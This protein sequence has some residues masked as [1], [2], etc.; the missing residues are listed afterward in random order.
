MTEDGRRETGD[1]GR[2]TEDEGTGKRGTKKLVDD[3][4]PNHSRSDFSKL[5]ESFA[6]NWPINLAIKLGWIVWAPRNYLAKGAARARQP[7]G[8]P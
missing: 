5:R 7:P 2:G 4:S 3:Q 8:E 1:G 6:D